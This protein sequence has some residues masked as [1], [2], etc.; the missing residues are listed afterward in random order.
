MSAGKSSWSSMRSKR[1][2]A[3]SARSYAPRPRKGCERRLYGIYLAHYAVRVLLAQTAGQ[4]ELDPDRLSFTEGLFELTEMISL[5]L[6]DGGPRRRLSRCWS[7]CGTRW[8]SMSCPP[9]V[10]ASIVGR[11]SRSTTSINPRSVRCLHL[12]PLRRRSSFSILSPCLI[13]SPLSLPEEGLSEMYWGQGP[14]E[15]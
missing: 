7:A 12:R 2:S 9:V 11:S 13:L 1:T 5:A 4:A 10:C 15:M 14:C 3:P 8:P 6:T